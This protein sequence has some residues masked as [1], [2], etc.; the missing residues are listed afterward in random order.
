MSDKEVGAPPLLVIGMEGFWGLLICTILLYPI[1][2][3]LPG[4]DHGSIEDPFN[5]AHMF[6]ASS[7]VQLM[8][9]LYFFR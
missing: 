1:V 8:F 5:T 6:M 2:Y 7:D 9:T 3:T 4:P